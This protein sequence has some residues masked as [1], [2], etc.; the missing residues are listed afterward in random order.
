MPDDDTGPEDPIGKARDGRT[1]P[2]RGENPFLQREAASDLRHNTALETP[3]AVISFKECE[4]RHAERV[5]PSEVPVNVI[6]GGIPFAVMMTTPS[7]LED[8]AVGFSLTEGVIQHPDDIRDIRIERE[9]R[10]LRLAVEL[11][12]S[13]L[14]EHLARKRALAG[15]TG[16]GLCGIDDLKALPQARHPQGDAPNIALSAIHSALLHLEQEQVLNQLTHAVHA[17][18]WADLD[19]TIRCVREDVGRH[20][21]LDKLIGSIARADTRPDGGF[22]VV[23]SRCSFELVEKVAA[24]GA[25][26]LVAISAPTSLALERARHHDITLIGI[27]RRDSISVF[28]GSERISGKSRA[29]AAGDLQG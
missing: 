10:G 5:I 23:T 29:C 12:P 7:E 16:C 25:R 6:Y 15:R 27:A 1:Q 18:A 28:H 21:A 19:G 11:T 8:F 2:P 14:H 17:A 4:T 20:N 13:R 26:T 22:V 24:F 3:I 9:E